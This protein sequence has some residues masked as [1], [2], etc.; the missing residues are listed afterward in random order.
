MFGRCDRLNQAECDH[1]VLL[2]VRTVTTTGASTT[3]DLC[4]VHAARSREWATGRGS[5]VVIAQTADPIEV[6]HG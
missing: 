6:R 3:E 4:S 1:R 2:R 5:H